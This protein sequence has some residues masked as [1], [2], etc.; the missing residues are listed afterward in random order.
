MTKEQ[1]D[2][3]V[4]KLLDNPDLYQDFMN[5]MERIHE[6]LNKDEITTAMM[7][8]AELCNRFGLDSPW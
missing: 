8:F 7:D 5:L 4:Q 6:G 1:A 2:T 3:F